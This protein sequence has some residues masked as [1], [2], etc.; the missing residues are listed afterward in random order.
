MTS[1]P[2]ELQNDECEQFAYFGIKPVRYKST[3]FDGSVNYYWLVREVD[4]EP[5]PFYEFW[6]EN[7]RG[8]TCFADEQNPGKSLIYLD[9][10][11]SFCKLFI[12]TGKHR[13]N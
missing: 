5:L 10:W 9:D 7:A 6:K 11:E 8:S 3:G 1:S 12:E 2:F 13:F 4:L